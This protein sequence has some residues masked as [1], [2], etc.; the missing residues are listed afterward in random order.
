MDDIQLHPDTPGTWQTFKPTGAEAWRADGELAGGRL[1]ITI[2]AANGVRCGRR[3]WCWEIAEADGGSWVS[4]ATGAERSRE[5]AV[6]W[7]EEAL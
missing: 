2:F 4:R 6:G 1:R 7:V 5:A 3:D